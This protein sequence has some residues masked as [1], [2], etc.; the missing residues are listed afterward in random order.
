[1][2]WRARGVGWGGVRCGTSQHV[3]AVQELLRRGANPHA[4]DQMGRAP[5]ALARLAARHGVAS[6]LQH[7]LTARDEHTLV[8]LL[9]R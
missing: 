3:H 2:A 1:M 9:Y 4:R 7:H 6:V 5:L 8:K